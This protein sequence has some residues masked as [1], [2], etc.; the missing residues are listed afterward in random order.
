LIANAGFGFCSNGAIL[1]SGDSTGGT[2]RV[3]VFG[4]GIVNC[5]FDVSAHNVPGVTVGSIEGD[6]LVLLGANNLTVGSNNLSTTFSGVIQDSGSLTKIGTGKLVLTNANTYTGATEVEA[7]ALVVNNT[8][9]FGTGTGPVEI[10]AG[11]LGGSGKIAGAVTVGTGAGAGAVLSPKMTRPRPRTLTIQGPITL[12]SD[13]TYKVALNSTHTRADKIVANGGVTIESGAYFIVLGSGQA[14]LPPGTVFTVIDNKSGMPIAGTFANLAD[15]SSF[16][17]NGNT[18]Q[19]SY[20]G[21][22]GND[23]TLTVQ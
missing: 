8:T 21:G 10:H 4:N 16:R 5:R 14:V 22:D 3:E 23:L 17:V 9:G 11:I 6:G 1:F 13:S 15:G 20:E 18:F 19:A 2:A 7:G 12:K